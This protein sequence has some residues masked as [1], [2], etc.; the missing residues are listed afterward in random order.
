MLDIIQLKFVR[1]EVLCFVGCAPRYT[2][3]IITNLMNY[4]SSG[5]FVNQPVHVSGIFVARHQEV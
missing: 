1:T 4:L 5:Y 2:S 3:V